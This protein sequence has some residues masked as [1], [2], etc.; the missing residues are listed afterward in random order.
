VVIA[1]ED[2]P[3]DKR[4]VAYLIPNDES[5]TVESLRVLARAV[6]PEHMVPS[7][8]V[9]LSLLPL[10]PSGKLDRRALPAP[11]ADAYGRRK[12]EAPQGELE[13]AL[14]QIWRGLL[15]IEQVGRDDSF[16]EL[17][18]HSLLAV[19]ACQKMAQAIGREVPL[20]KL[21]MAPTLAQFARSLQDSG[22]PAEARH[23][24]R[25]RADQSARHAIYFLPTVFGMG[26]YF[27]GWAPRLSGQLDVFSCNLPL[28]TDAA[29]QVSLPTIRDIAAYCRA[30][31]LEERV[32]GSFSLVGWSFGGVVAHELARQLSV[33]GVPP[34]TLVL[35]D[36][37]LVSSDLASIETFPLEELRKMFD[38]ELSAA[39]T[40]GNPDPASFQEESAL[41]AVF[42]RYRSNVEALFRHEALACDVRT[43]EI[44]AAESEALLREPRTGPRAL[45]L[46]RS[47]LIILP[48]D[49]YSIVGPGSLETVV[50][51][52][53]RAAAG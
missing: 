19:T 4:L 26:S 51:L 1:R 50:K 53:D 24:L 23:R 37:Y 28:A 20:A 3:A 18:G 49:H 35:I 32:P 6:L 34:R 29:Q 48:G 12:Y 17:G 27:A 15:K 7:A 21:F 43:I 22:S 13:T 30:Q 5:V 14:A 11:E 31:M 10:T 47:E 25:F 42:Q 38:A 36:S 44:R 45:P 16:F 9:L 41:Q 40:I 33:E 52:I 2:S 8:F 46:Q 39:R